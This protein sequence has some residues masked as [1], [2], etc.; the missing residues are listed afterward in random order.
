MLYE[1][2]MEG[3]VVQGGCG[4]AHLVASIEANSFQEAC[5]KHFSTVGDGIY[6]SSQLSYWGCR[7]FDNET[8]A[9]RT[10]G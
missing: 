6:R 3:Y 2:W 1:I 7:L 10:F 9:K 8:D 4:H 5:D